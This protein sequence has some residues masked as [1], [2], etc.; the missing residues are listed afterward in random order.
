MT[1]GLILSRTMSDNVFLMVFSR[2]SGRRFFT[3]P[4]GLPGLGGVIMSP[5]FMS[6]S[7]C[8]SNI[9]LKHSVMVLV[10]SSEP[11]LYSSPGI[12]SGPDALLLLRRFR[13]L[14]TSEV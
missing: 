6:M 7:S 2:V 13:F 14:E 1:F 8:F 5:I 10:R 11:Y 4:F 12:A 9:R 3:G